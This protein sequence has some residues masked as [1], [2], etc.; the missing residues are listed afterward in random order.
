VLGREL[1]EA[2]LADWH[3]APEPVR[4]ML[5]LLR[6]MTLAPDEVA[7]E[8]VEAVRRAGVADQAIVDALRVGALFN[9]IDRIADALGFVV[10]TPEAFADA[11]PAFFERGYA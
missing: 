3:S 6:K 9:V 4:S 11:A 5:G 8:D 2:A 10:P 1:V 7:P